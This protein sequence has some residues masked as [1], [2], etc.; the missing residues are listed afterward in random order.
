MIDKFLCIGAFEHTSRDE[1]LLACGIRTVMNVRAIDARSERR[2]DAWFVNARIDFFSKRRGLARAFRSR[3][4]AFDVVR[5]RS[6]VV[7]R[8]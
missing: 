6:I 3:S 5:T 8:V 1:A 4:D 2:F 7:R